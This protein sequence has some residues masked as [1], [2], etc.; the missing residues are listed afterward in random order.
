[1]RAYIQ[2]NK[3]VMFISYSEML[4]FATSRVEGAAPWMGW[5]NVITITNMLSNVQRTMRKD[6]A[7]SPQCYHTTYFRHTIKDIFFAKFVPSI[8]T[9]LC[10]NKKQYF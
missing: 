2:Y 1:M 3:I 7:H 8:L 6:G 4:S 9:C 10:L 5:K